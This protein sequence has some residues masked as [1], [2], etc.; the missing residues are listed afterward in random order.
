MQ[1]YVGSYEE[2][3]DS[4]EP[5]S[6]VCCLTKKNLTLEDEVIRFMNMGNYYL[7][8]KEIL[9]LLELYLVDAIDEYGRSRPADTSLS[10]YTIPNTNVILHY[11][12]HGTTH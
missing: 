5:K 7:Q 1:H 12:T 11:Y 3:V 6:P 9:I 2:W 10:W 4:L 8:L